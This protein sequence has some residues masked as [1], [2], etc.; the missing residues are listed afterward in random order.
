MARFLAQPRAVACGAGFV[1]L[2]LGEFLAHRH[3]V[4]LVV[5]AMHV[6]EHTLE[7]I[8]ARGETAARCQ[9]LECNGFLAAAVEN[10][11]VD[12]L[13]QRLPRRLKIEAVMHRQALQHH[14]KELV[15]F[16]PALDRAGGQ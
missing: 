4:G 3:R 16:V 5:A 9:R 7:R 1:V 15:A 11:V 14:E 8:A 6:G 12:T 13:R 10:H 2:V